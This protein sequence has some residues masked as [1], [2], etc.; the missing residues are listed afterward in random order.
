MATAGR[1]S[2]ASRFSNAQSRGG[3][4]RAQAAPEVGRL[5]GADV[6]VDGLR[7]L[8]RLDGGDD[9]CAAAP[10]SA[11]SAICGNAA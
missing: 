8:R 1:S 2:R 3:P 6:G 10:V 7:Q 11:A 4:D 9:P 5:D